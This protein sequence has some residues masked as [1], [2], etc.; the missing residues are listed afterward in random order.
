MLMALAEFRAENAML[1]AQLSLAQKA[2]ADA[3][4][5]TE[6]ITQELHDTKQQLGATRQQLEASKGRETALKA[7]V[8]VQDLELAAW[9]ASNVDL[10]QHSSL[11]QSEISALKV[12]FPCLH[13]VTAAA[14]PYNITLS[15]E[16]YCPPLIRPVR[17]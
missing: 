14:V 5:R 6:A 1:Q 2:A 13:F 12:R 11:L 8:E 15:P 17:S 4:S 16:S 7:K 10:R 9:K 3:Q